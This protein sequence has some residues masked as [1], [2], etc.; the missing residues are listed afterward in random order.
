MATFFRN[1]VIKEVGTQPI[2]VITTD[3][4]TRSVVLGV[5]LNNLT[6]G[7]VYASMKLR[8]DTSVEGFYLKD[9][10]I[11]PN[12]SLRAIP[13]GEKLILAGDNSLIIEADINAAYDAVIS[14]VDIV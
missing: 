6:E 7:I 11:P 4:G 9:I 13:P 2:T 3:A 14:Y 10:M 5:S 12:S 8:D 1:K